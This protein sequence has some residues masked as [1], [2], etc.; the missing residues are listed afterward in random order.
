MVYGQAIGIA[1]ESR[2][3]DI[4]DRILYTLDLR[5]VT[6]SPTPRTEPISCDSHRHRAF[7]EPKSVTCGSDSII[8]DMKHILTS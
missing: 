8:C 7:D 2:R 3:L 1:L 6:A 5:F 4:L